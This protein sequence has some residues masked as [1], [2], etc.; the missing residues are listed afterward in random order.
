M[1]ADTFF[2]IIDEHT[3]TAAE[4]VVGLVDDPDADAEIAADVRAR[5]LPTAQSALSTRADQAARQG[6]WRY[7]QTTLVEKN[8]EAQEADDAVT[9]L[10]L[11]LRLKG[12]DVYTTHRQLWGGETASELV[13][14][15]YPSQIQA[16][17][18]YVARVDADPAAANGPAERIERVRE[19]NDAL[20]VAWKAER[21][22]K[23]AWTVASEAAEDARDTFLTDYRATVRYLIAVYGEE[24]VRLA[25]PRLPRV[26]KKKG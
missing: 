22:A 3:Y 18:G 4:H 2:P 23:R 8:E 15:P 14:R 24:R 11:A 17:R 25:L 12:E 9:D 21:E 16:I 7:A 5:L 6:L 10:N 26:G 1:S 13:K 19:T 20:E